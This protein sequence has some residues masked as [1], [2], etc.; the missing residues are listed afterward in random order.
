VKRDANW[1]LIGLTT[2][3]AC[4]GCTDDFDPASRVVSLRVLA[5]QADHPLARPDSDVQLS[6]LYYDPKPETLSWAWGPCDSEASSSAFA[7]LQKL[8]FS[9]LTIGNEPS[10]TLH[11]PPQGKDQSMSDVLGVA[12]VAC[13]GT[14][15]QGDTLGIPIRCLDPHGEALDLDAFEIGMKRVYVSEE[16][17]NHN[18]MID[19]VLWDGE[20]WPD[21]EVREAHCDEHGKCKKHTI[22]LRAP[23]AEEHGLDAA[24]VSISEQVVVQFYATGGTFE[25][26]VRTL[27]DPDTTWKP[28][29]EDRGK[30]LDFWFEIRDDRGGVS[31]VARRVRVP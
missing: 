14:I 23:D 1:L 12:V 28:R 29:D 5:V 10:Y 3:L 21:D 13:P 24:G 11:V 20:R 30:E 15:S 27:A 8:E 6:A 26:D 9:A 25:D 4:H 19:M 31:W 18:P 7:C 16:G 22:E 17:E 2:F